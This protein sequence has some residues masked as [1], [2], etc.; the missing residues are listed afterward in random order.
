MQLSAR[1]RTQLF[2]FSVE[3]TCRHVDIL[4]T[5]IGQKHRNHAVFARIDHNITD[6]LVAYS[7]LAAGS[8]PIS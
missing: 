4:A 3:L 1:N 2:H 7:S 6:N 5:E 8:I